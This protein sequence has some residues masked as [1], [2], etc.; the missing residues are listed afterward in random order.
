MS[1]LSIHQYI[2]DIFSF[3]ALCESNLL[4]VRHV[5]VITV[6]GVLGREPPTRPHVFEVQRLH[7]QDGLD[8]LDRDHL[9][10]GDNKGLG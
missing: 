4:S 2:N 10:L 7:L 8:P 9:H 3:V 5:V 6:A 1:K